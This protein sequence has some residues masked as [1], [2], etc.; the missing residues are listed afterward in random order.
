[1]I[2]TARYQNRNVADD[3]F[4]KVAITVGLPK[5]QLGYEL[6]GRIKELAP[7]SLMN[8]HNHEVFVVKYTECLDRIGVRRIRERLLEFEQ[9]GKDTVLLCYE[10]IEENKHCHRRA[11]ADWWREKTGELIDELPEAKEVRQLAVEVECHSD[12][13]AGPMKP[14]LI[15]NTKP[16][17]QNKLF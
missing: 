2:Y 15:L 9:E 12:N 5:F 14:P 3:K 10:N 7:W 6:A 13:P 4:V 17:R 8:E 16:F 1:M 11:F